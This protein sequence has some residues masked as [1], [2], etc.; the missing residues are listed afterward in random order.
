MIGH[1]AV[2]GVGFTV[3]L[4]IAGLAF[5]DELLDDAKLGVLTASAMSSVFVAVLLARA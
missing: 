4:F 5:T 3:S 1:G 2:A